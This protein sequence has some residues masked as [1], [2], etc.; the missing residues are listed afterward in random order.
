MEID[1]RAGT[2][3]A[4][5]MFGHQLLQ[6]NH[7]ASEQ[8]DDKLKEL[9]EARKAL[10]DA[11]IARRAKL[12]Q[13]L[14][15]QLFQRDC[16]LAETWM[17]AREA[18]LADSVDGSGDSVEAL[19]KKHEDFDRAINSQEEKIAALQSFATQLTSNDHYDTPGVE[20]RRDD[21]L[22]RY[23]KWQNR[24]VPHQWVFK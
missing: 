14:E 12:D 17:A 7:Y 19:L 4:F 22:E 21:V 10:E 18:S 20:Q 8:V 23:A 2:F 9:T 1:A 16:E 3:Q 13:C 11:W 5:E 15:L 24:I 6:N